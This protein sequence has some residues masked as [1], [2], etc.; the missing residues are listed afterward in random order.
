MP[1]I[2]QCFLPQLYQTQWNN[3]DCSCNVSVWTFLRP[4][5]ILSIWVKIPFS[6]NTS[7]WYRCSIFSVVTLTSQD[8]WIIFAILSVRFYYYPKGDMQAVSLTKLGQNPVLNLPSCPLDCR[9]RTVLFHQDQLS[10]SAC[11]HFWSVLT[12]GMCVSLIQSVLTFVLTL[13]LSVGQVGGCPKSGFI[14][15][16]CW[17]WY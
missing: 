4:F 6:D 16:W 15:L 12:F 13:V 5:I 7:K 10:L 9:L 17:F 8:K 14:G 1:N 3:R 2:S 11:R